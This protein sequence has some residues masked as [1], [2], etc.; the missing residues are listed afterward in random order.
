MTKTTWNLINS[1]LGHAERKGEEFAQVAHRSGVPL[2]PFA[3]ARSEHPLLKFTLGD[4]RDAF[5][6]Q[7]E[8]HRKQ[9]RFLL[10]LNTKYDT[11]QSPGEHHPRTRFS[12]G[13]ELAHYFLEPHRAYLI[14]GGKSHGSESEFKSDALVEREADAFAAGL[15][16][17]SFLFSPRVNKTEPDFDVIQEVA[18][19][20]QTSILSTAIRTV[21]LSHFPCGL[22]CIRQSSLAWMFCSNSLIEAGC[23][24]GERGSLPPETALMAWKEAE[25][26]GLT[27][28][29]KEGVVGDWFRTY[30]ATS[31]ESI[32]V[33][34]H[35]FS[36][37]VMNSLLVLLTLD[38][39]DLA[40]EED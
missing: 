39:D 32:F 28:R 31:R 19:D 3:L 4:F 2:D 23:Y 9:N 36:I 16:M 25:G 35:Y 1:R 38:E 14:R 13:H 18:S 24:P 27:N 17:P 15:L 8:Y 26:G 22:A 40:Q 29:T 11:G 12:M 21:Q 37:P 20:F 6:G 34:E 7:L 10:F 30:D 33:Y 5:D